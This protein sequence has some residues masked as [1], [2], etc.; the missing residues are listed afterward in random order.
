MEANGFRALEENANNAGPGTHAE[1]DHMPAKERCV[2][3]RCTE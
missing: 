1:P 3:P 2:V